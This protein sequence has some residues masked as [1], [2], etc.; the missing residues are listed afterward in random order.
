[1]GTVISV[2]NFK[3][4]V[5]KTTLSVNLAASLADL[6]KYE[7]LL[8]DLD[9]QSNAST[10]LMGIDDWQE[11]CERNNDTESSHG[12]FRNKSV[13][14]IKPF[15]KVTE[16]HIP[17][18]SLIPA[19]FRMISLENT[20]FTEQG[21]LRLQN[22]YQDGAE[23]NYLAKQLIK[24]RK[25][26][27]YII[28]DSPPNI[29]TATKNAVCQSDYI[30]IPCIPDSL[31]TSGLNIL[32]N[33]LGRFVKRVLEKGQLKQSPKLLGVVISKL[34]KWNEHEKGVHTIH[35]FIETAIENK[36][37]PLIDGDSLVL[38]DYPLREYAAHTEAVQE[39]K[40]LCLSNPDSK[41]YKDMKNL[42]QAIIDRME[43]D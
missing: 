24:L 39:Y 12:L 13:K 19:T 1:M 32:L 21:L 18:F 28:I 43:S 15:S 31:S 6:Y 9:P 23:Y 7:T 2:I 17:S 38:D 25:E 16:S 20:I 27:D 33:E 11:L 41:A 26:Y 36:D 10:W 5:G 3:G 42:T 4:G 14:V 30:L 40:P 35:T 29:Y 22:K 34:K 8:I 37:N